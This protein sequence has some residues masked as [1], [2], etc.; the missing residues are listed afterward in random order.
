M[1]T[2][3]ESRPHLQQRDHVTHLDEELILGLLSRRQGA[4]IA[5]FG[6]VGDAL[7]RRIAGLHGQNFARRRR[8]Q[9][10]PEGFDQFAEEL[11][12]SDRFTHDAAQ[13]SGPGSITQAP[14]LPRSRLRIDDSVLCH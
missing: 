10:T 13:L 5:T 6:Q 11:G 14:N 8:G 3:I 2:Q 12:R 4:A 9:R 7:L 1:L